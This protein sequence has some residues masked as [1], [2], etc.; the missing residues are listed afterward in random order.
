MDALDAEAGNTAQPYR[1]WCVESY[2]V[3][4]VSDHRH[5]V[6]VETADAGG[7]TTRWTLVRAIAAIR[8]GELF[9]V[10]DAGWGRPRSSNR[11]SA[12]SARRPPWSATR[13]TR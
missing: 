4:E 8:D 12:P 3:D 9:V 6:A 11:R 1:V 7:R 2:D 5:V 13:R 10:G